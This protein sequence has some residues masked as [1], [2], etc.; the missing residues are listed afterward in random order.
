MRT[1]FS[2]LGLM[3]LLAATS[4]QAVVVSGAIT[5]G[6]AAPGTFTILTP[7][8]S[9]GDNDQQQNNRLY[10]WDEQQGVL[11]AAPLMTDLGGIIAA[12]TR[13]DSHGIVFDPRQ[14]RTLVG[15]VTFDRAIVGVIWGTSRLVAT[16][17][18]LGLPTITYK[19]PS[20]RGLEQRDI[21]GT[22]FI[23]KTLFINDWQASS[24]GDNIR[25]LTAGP[26]PEPATW[27]MMIAGFGLVGFAARRRRAT[28][29][30]A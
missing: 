17:G 6:S 28:S 30:A 10:A 18:L 11:L 22:S 29:I 25:V 15:S 23:G 21:P 5:G 26:V 14:S 12:G 13:V 27:A 20:A 24:P 19:S 7:P 4:A 1:A 3:A 16:D 2:A 9:V 8:F